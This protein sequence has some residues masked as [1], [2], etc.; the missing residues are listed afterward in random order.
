MTDQDDGW[1]RIGD[2]SFARFGK[3]TIVFSRSDTGQSYSVEVD[4][5]EQELINV[6]VG[7]HTLE[8]G[9][10]R[11]MH[12]NGIFQLRGGLSDRNDLFNIDRYAWIELTLS[13]PAV[14]EYW[15]TGVLFRK[16]E[17]ISGEPVRGLLAFRR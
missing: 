10:D 1:E 17:E 8:L 6:L 2:W 7:A 11:K 9:I 15:G 16:D 5:D 12:R 3:R 14:I 13:Q 4:E